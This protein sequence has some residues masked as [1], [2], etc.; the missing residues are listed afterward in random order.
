MNFTTPQ[1][2]EERTVALRYTRIHEDAIHAI[3]T[4]L[5]YSAM[6]VYLYINFNCNLAS[7]ITHR[8]SYSRIAEYWGI[9]LRS[10]YRGIAELEEAGLI[11][12]K[13]SGDFM[14]V[15]PHQGLI[16]KLAA[17]Q[18]YEKKERHFYQALRERINEK[19]EG[20]TAPLPFGAVCR[21]YEALI[22]ERAKGK[23]FYPKAKGF[24]H[25]QEKLDLYAPVV[26]D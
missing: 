8:L 9:T 13:D 5:S 22:V 23:R 2:G 11:F 16:Q 18:S 1:N 20:R 26:E 25:L 17:Q 19:S 15:I 7:G 12:M 10:V 24:G 6:K 14:G 4:E 3:G 21:L